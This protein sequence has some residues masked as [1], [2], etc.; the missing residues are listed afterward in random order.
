MQVREEIKNNKKNP[1]LDTTG[2]SAVSIVLNVDTS[3]S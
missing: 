3:D 1:V 2:G